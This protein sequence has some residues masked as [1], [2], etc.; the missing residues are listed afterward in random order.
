[1]QASAYGQED[2]DEMKLWVAADTV[3]LHYADPNFNSVCV[4][5]LSG[6]REQAIFD[7]RVM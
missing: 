5:F 6:Y 3:A 2:L 4:G 1:M 7:L